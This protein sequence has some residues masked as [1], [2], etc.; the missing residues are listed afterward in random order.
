MCHGDFKPF[1]WHRNL[2][3]SN[4]ASWIRAYSGINSQPKSGGLVALEM[5]STHRTTPS[6]NKN[7]LFA[8]END[9]ENG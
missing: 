9:M 5:S 3:M 1:L 4:G 2:Y 7:T 8:M 6:G